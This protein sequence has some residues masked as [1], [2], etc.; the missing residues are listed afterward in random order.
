MLLSNQSKGTK[1]N[2]VMKSDI[3]KDEK[4][5]KLLKCGGKIELLNDWF[6]TDDNLGQNLLKWNTICDQQQ[7]KSFQNI[8]EQFNGK[9]PV[10]IFELLF[11]HEIRSHIINETERSAAV[12]HNDS[13]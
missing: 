1:I 9:L 4:V 8:L 10:E 5:D 3:P 7:H 6:L 2:A 11:N 13:A 12:A